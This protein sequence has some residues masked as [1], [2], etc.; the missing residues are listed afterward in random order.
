MMFVAHNANADASQ[1]SFVYGQHNL[2]VRQAVRR[3]DGAQV[4]PPSMQEH[5]NRK[6]R[7]YDAPT[8][9]DTDSRL[10]R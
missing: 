1:E 5:F 4:Q 3:T 2:G 8:K 7:R 9:W 10:R 6:D